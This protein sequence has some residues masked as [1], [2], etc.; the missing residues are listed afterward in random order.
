MRWFHCV[1]AAALLGWTAACA[2]AGGVPV[3][4]YHQITDEKP[5]GDTVISPARFAQQMD[6]LA[7]EGY[8]TLSM[9][10]LVAVMQARRPLPPKAVVLTFDDGWRNVLAALPALDRHRFRASFWIVTDFVRDP[11]YLDWAQIKALARNPRYEIQGHTQT[12]PSSDSNNL[13][14]WTR[15]E[16]PGRS[17]DDVRRELVDSKRILEAHLKRRVHYL[18]WPLGLFNEAMIQVAV[19]SGYR[20]LL[21][22]DDGVGNG[23]G[24]DP[25]RIRRTGVNGRCAL[26]VFIAQLADHGDRDMC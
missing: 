3:L 20:G 13:L 2:A 7:R 11:N 18:A 8:V 23:P 24:A 10:E 17:L 19:E 15:G 21:T 22:T 26:E 5:P 14:T 12:H 4:M 16:T 6:Y 25:L 9:D 1:A